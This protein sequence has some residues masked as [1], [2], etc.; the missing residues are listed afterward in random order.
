[1]TTH[2]QLPW[3]FRNTSDD[4]KMILSENEKYICSIQIWQTPRRMGYDMEEERLA[5]AA[6][7]VHCVNNHE[8]L[9]EALKSIADHE[10]VS[11]IRDEE[12]LQKWVNEFV[13]TAKQA[14]QSA[15]DSK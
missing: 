7:I 6:F 11:G 5:N 3:K 14:L 2:S 4:Q 13:Y 8:R 1:M 12:M 9:V 15:E 10:W